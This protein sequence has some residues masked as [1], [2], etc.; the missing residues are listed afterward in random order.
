MLVGKPTGTLSF[1]FDDTAPVLCQ[2]IS[3]RIELKLPA[4]TDFCQ[5]AEQNLPG[6]ILRIGRLGLSWTLPPA[7]FRPGALSGE[8]FVSLGSMLGIL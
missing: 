8:N 2:L 6:P 5:L 4:G 7:L 3:G 1:F